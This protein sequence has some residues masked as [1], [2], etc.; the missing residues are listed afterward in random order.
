LVIGGGAAGQVICTHLSRAPDLDVLKIADLDLKKVKTYA[1]WLNNEKVSVQ[2]LNASNEGAVAKLARGM[3]LLVNALEPTYNLTIMK[4]AFRAK[5]KY[6]DLAFGPPYETLGKELKQDAKWKK[7]GLT[8]ITGTG[9]SPGITNILASVGADELDVVEGIKI[10]VFSKM[11][12]TQLIST[13]SPATMIED[14]MGEPT[15]YENAHFKV[16][17]PFGGEEIYNFPEPIGPQ[18]VSY[19]AHEEPHTLPRFI[20]KGIRYVGFK[21]GVN[22]LMEDLLRIGLLSKKPVRVKGA[23]VA[24]I[25]VVI[26]CY[27]KPLGIEELRAK[28]EAGIVRGSIGCDAVEV[29]G[30]NEGRAIRQTYFVRWPDIKEVNR[31]MPHATHTSYMAGTGAAIL[32]EALARGQIEM[33]GVIAPECLERRVREDFLAELP[34]RQID[35]ERSRADEQNR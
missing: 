11:N 9:N 35:I 33:K 25:D 32:T 5:T 18:N 31:N 19:H 7:A 6:Q 20:G 4:A 3:D 14:M 30:K 22:P 21:Y 24:P 16:V 13:W 29:W 34:R 27:P 28:I 1:G 12:S 17:P 2:K 15:I 26:S 8:A 10:V 23:K